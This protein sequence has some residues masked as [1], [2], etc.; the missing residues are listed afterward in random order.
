MTRTAAAL[1]GAAVSAAILLRLPEASER[2]LVQRTARRFAANAA[3]TARGADATSDR[4]LSRLSREHASRRIEATF[5]ELAPEEGTILVGSVRDADFTLTFRTVAYL[6]W[7]RP[8]AIVSCRAD[9]SVNVLIPTPPGT[10]HTRAIYVGKT[11]PADLRAATRSLAA[12][13]TIA[14]LERE[15]DWTSYCSP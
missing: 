3:W 5:A 15:Q 10:R 1:V 13:W 7:P 9:G 12:G 11:P 14:T 8:L 6:V 2:R 4:F